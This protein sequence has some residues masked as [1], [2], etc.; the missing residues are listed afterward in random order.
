MS[1]DS[2]SGSSTRSMSPIHVV[3]STKMDPLHDPHLRI[4][5]SASLCL[6]LLCKI[7][8]SGFMSQHPCVSQDPL[9][10]PC[11]RVHVS[12]SLYLT[13]SL[14][15]PCLR[16]HVSASL[17]LTDS[18]QDPCL[19]I[20]V[21]DSCLSIPPIWILCKIH[22]SGFMSQHVS[23][24]LHLRILYKIHVFGFMSQHLR[25]SGSSTRSMCPF[26]V[27]ASTKMDPLQDPHLRIHVSTSLYLLDSLQDPRLRIHVAASIC[28]SRSSARSMSPDSCLSIFVSQDPLQDPCLR[29]H[30]SPSFY[31]RKKIRPPVS[32]RRN[33][34]FDLRSRV[35]CG[36]AQRKP[37]R[38][39]I[40]T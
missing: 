13:D 32:R 9:E 7:H 24:S 10:N 11:L 38:T 12:A 3:A 4:H 35:F 29:I 19:R 15:D 39:E 22:V 17:Y 36:T 25:I 2:C 30:V 33:A 28:I 5:V 40:C 20:H 31:L 1:P 8:V 27:L 21:S 23:A 26:H 14:Q 37:S 18:R 34:N 16:I 6:K